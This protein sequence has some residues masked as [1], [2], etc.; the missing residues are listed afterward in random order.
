M[1]DD[2]AWRPPTDLE[3]DRAAG[4][5]A[6]A[7]LDAD[8]GSGTPEASPWSPDASSREPELPAAPAPSLPA[9][10]P[11]GP[12]MP[13]P[14]S[15]PTP[16]PEP[17]FPETTVAGPFEPTGAPFGAPPGS[18]PDDTIVTRSPEPLAP[19]SKRSKWLVGSAAA[20]VV[21]VGAAGVFAVSNLTGSVEGGAA[22]PDELGL[23]LM[24]AV[25]NEDVLGVID[26]LSPGERD[27][28]RDP[29]VDLVGELTRLEVLSPDADLARILGLDVELTNES[30][31][32]ESTNVPD[33]AN[34]DMTADAVVSIDGAEVPIGDLI[35]DNVPD[36]MLTE[37][38]G[39]RITETD[40]FDLEMTA[41]AIDGR[42]Y[43]SLFH[44][45]AEA[46]RSEFDPSVDIPA[47][48]I[49]ADGADTPEAA[50][51]GLLDTVEALDLTGLMRR[52]NPGEAAALQRYAPLFVDEAQPILDEVPLTWQIV[53]REFRV[54]GDGDTRTVLIDGLA[55]EGTFDGTPFSVSA[56]DGCFRAEFEGETIEQCGT[57][58]APAELD[59]ILADA[60][61]AAALLD[62][63]TE[64]FADIEEVGLE[65]RRF[66]G[67]WYVSPVSTLTEG[68]LT[69]L[70]ALDRSEIDA[71]VDQAPA[72]FE[73]FSDA[74]FGGL[75]ALPGTI[76]G[77]DDE[78]GFIIDDETDLF[79]DFDDFDDVDDG[80][81]FDDLEVI[82]GDMDPL[83]AAW[84]DCYA[85]TDA[86]EA[87]DCF[88]SVTAAG[89]PDASFMPL[90]LRFP[91][92]GYAASWEPGF[93]QLPD[94]EFI[95][96]IETARPCFLD[97][98]EQG[99]IMEWEL[100]SEIENLE[101]YE[102]RNWYQVF[103]DPEY[104]ERYFA[105]VGGE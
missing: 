6:S 86:V 57:G 60:P 31:R 76:G 72:A 35:T 24:T 27:V 104:D 53:T 29:M 70:R 92:C 93:Y 63:V 48:G 7:P 3:G 23:A 41:V 2:A 102:G 44:T 79:D 45:A 51:N 96:A 10:P 61:E 80:D 49:G 22:S 5:E 12:S 26:V 1:Q 11:A 65:L 71:I 69:V 67:Q 64:A 46:A 105:C 52:L 21:A 47:T 40:T 15:A 36:D 97:L 87:T 55:I 62:I 90:A 39:T 8:A 19:R 28:F 78:G 13:P 101:C 9:P 82:D 16:P 77:I 33:I 85:V 81:A 91:E 54:V 37:M 89:G 14:T 38:R 34:I 4:H 73:E 88:T 20:A 68:F 99:V 75:N 59:E 84:S 56:D 50:V 98:V 83:D 25:E 66:D 17:A 42:W 94:D 95:G 43:F 30:V 58:T 100:P 103:D 32:V 74:I 18:S